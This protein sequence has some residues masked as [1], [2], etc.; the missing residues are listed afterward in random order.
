MKT[1]RLTFDVQR[2]KTPIP[3]FIHIFQLVLHTAPRVFDVDRREVVLARVI[4]EPI[5]EQHP[6]GS[7]GQLRP[8]VQED[9]LHMPPN[10]EEQSLLLWTCRLGI[11]MCCPRSLW[12]RHDVRYRWSDGFIRTGCPHRSPCQ[13]SLTPLHRHRRYRFIRFG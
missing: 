2:Q 7:K 9:L 6:E 3:N 13:T 4:R 5:D 8:G 11:R 10:L 12:M 1:G